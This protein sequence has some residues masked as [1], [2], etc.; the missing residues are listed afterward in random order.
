MAGFDNEV[1]FAPGIRL[2]ASSAQ[3]IELMQ[4]TST[5][6]S[7]V[8]FVGNPNDQVA[9]NPGSLS[10]DPVNGNLWLK[11]SGTG[12]TI[13]GQLVPA[14]EGEVITL[15]GNSGGAIPPDNTGNI[16]ILTAH[17][18]PIFAGSGHTLTVDFLDAT[19]GNLLLGST[20]AQTL[21]PLDAQGLT[22]IGARAL[23]NV[24]SSKSCVAVG[25]A[26][27]AALT[28][29]SFN[30]MTGYNSALLL[31][32]GGSN[33][34]H[35]YAALAACVHGTSNCAFGYT[36]LEA[37]TG[38]NNIALGTSALS[39]VVNCSYNLAI[40]PS[41]GLQY[42]STESNNITI[43]NGGVTGESNV[44]RIGTN[45][46]G[47]AEQSS[48]YIAGITGVTASGS[49]PV[50]INSSSQL[51]S[52]G[53]GTSGQVLTSNGASTSPTWQPILPTQFPWLDASGTFTAAINT[54]YFLTGTST[55]T[56]PA[57]PAQGDII[58]F[59]VD[60]AATMTIT[61][62]TSQVIQYAGSTSASAG[63]LAASTV[64]NHVRLVYRSANT[65]WNAIGSMGAA[66]TVT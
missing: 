22:S 26:S 43:Y 40:G 25:G 52:L 36:A 39:N 54:G 48:C 65:S 9:A 51:S 17:S 8:N 41:A 20:V 16:N 35:G 34:G 18:S 46:S 6:V 10:H 13:W 32:D 1:M 2:Q 15:T 11:V 44:L 3:D 56:L 63:T 23:D 59:F 42:T 21:N 53:F 47:T 28:T 31:T 19:F 55:P 29:G 57:S 5:D 27:L 37:C 12:T 33:T 38:S 66:W 24:V 61:A 14:G 58:E 60:A 62:N 49:A 45:G 50:G 30:T 7:D 4:S 64:G